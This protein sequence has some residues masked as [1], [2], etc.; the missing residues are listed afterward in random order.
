M[1]WESVGKAG[2]QQFLG[3]LR[4]ECPK[5][6]W[7][8]PHETRALSSGTVKSY[9]SSLRTFCNWCIA[10]GFLTSSPMENMPAPIDRPD[11]V[12]PFTQN[13]L[14]LLENSAKKNRKVTRRDEAIFLLLLDTGI[15]ASELCSLSVKDINMASSSLRV[16][17]AKGG[18]ARTLPFSRDTKRVLFEYLKE[19]DSHPDDPVFLCLR[20]PGVGNRLARLGLLHLIY[21]WGEN[22]GITRARCSPHTFRHTFAVSFL[23]NGGDV[24]TL[25]E[26]LGHTSLAMVNRYVALSQADLSRQHSQHSPVNSFKKTKGKK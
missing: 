6:R 15:R 24:F 16:E 4:R 14:E 25:K 1:Q 8:N 10:E 22:A 2:I 12:Q 26:L 9:H 11:Q 21:R 23:R 18:K 3:Y 13:E 5:G 19:Y 7:G 20:G 17:F